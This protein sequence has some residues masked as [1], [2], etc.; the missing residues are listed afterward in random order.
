ME[1]FEIYRGVK[2]NIVDTSRAAPGVVVAWWSACGSTADELL[3]AVGRG[4]FLTNFCVW[5]YRF[6]NS[7]W[8]QKACALSKKPASGN[9][10]ERREP[11]GEFLPGRVRPQLELAESLVYY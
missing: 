6:C 11:S 9:D 1:T 2:R 7:I 4:R 5:R 8:S 10:L 3:R